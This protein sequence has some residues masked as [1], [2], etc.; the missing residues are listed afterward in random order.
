[1]AK[2]KLALLCSVLG[3]MITGVILC[4]SGIIPVTALSYGVGPR[5]RS[6]S[7]RSLTGVLPALGPIPQSG[8]E[9]AQESEVQTELPAFS[10]VPVFTS[11]DYSIAVPKAPEGAD[12]IVVKQYPSSVTINNSSKKEIN[13]DA[14]L[15][16]VPD[17]DLSGEG[18]QILIVHTHTSE[19][20]NETGQDWYSGQ[21]TRTTDNSRNMVRMGE[22]LSNTLSQAGYQ[23]IHCQKR[24]DE[25]FNASYGKSLR[26]VA[27][28]LEK[29]PSIALVIDLHR[30]SLIGDS[31]TKYRPTVTIDGE[32]TA[33][34][35]FLMGV[36]NDTYPHPT[37]EDNLSLALRI[38]KQ[39]EAS[40]PGWMRPLLVR[41]LLYN[42]HLSPGAMLVELGACGNSP[43][44]AEAAA[45]RFGEVCAKALDQ[46][47]KEQG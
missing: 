32:P 8:E 2:W 30:D 29:Y 41:P 3:A 11:V 31:G 10:E 5:I 9:S 7:V 6:L 38:Q 47:R 27:E 22:V 18:P 28:Y 21:D 42:Q 13:V 26:S 35:M 43:A 23:V 25:D 36:G 33:Q 12:P 45:R 37:W 19:S 39:G 15:K 34:V 4:C 1:M 44:E 24:H 17:L 16:R 40:Y 20:Y 14:L 46:I